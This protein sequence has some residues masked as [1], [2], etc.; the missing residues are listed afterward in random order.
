MSAATLELTR[1]ALRFAATCVER[2]DW[3]AL[4]DTGIG[5]E[6]ARAL[7]NLKLS[8]LDLLEQRLDGHVLQIHFDP[9]A[10]RIVMD[11][12]HSD[13]KLKETK[14]ELIKRDA[15]AD[16]ME[17]LFGMGGKQYN[18]MRRLVRAPRAVGRPPE[19]DEDSVRKIW[20][21]WEALG[22][23]EALPTPT[24]WISLSDQSGFSVR[25]VWRVMQRWFE[26]KLHDSTES[27]IRAGGG[28]S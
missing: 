25:T 10:L 26:D 4:R 24:E 15:P 16:M 5:E 14:L 22:N 27:G 8:E 1:A 17:A 21:T 3:A 12:I 7:S 11:Q 19:V 13:A 9:T 20:M 6:D 18:M 23:A 28:N 2:G